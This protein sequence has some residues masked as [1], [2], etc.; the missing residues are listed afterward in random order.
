M[1]HFQIHLSNTKQAPDKTEAV[2][3]NGLLYS[4]V[5][6]RP[7]ILSSIAHTTT[8]STSNMIMCVRVS[9]LIESRRN[10]TPPL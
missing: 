8:A 1:G 2:I 4:H 3:A 6:G 7:R 5:N 9:M 10:S